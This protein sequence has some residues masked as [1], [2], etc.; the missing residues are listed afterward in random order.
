MLNK[1]DIKQRYVFIDGRTVAGM[2]R[3]LITEALLARQLL[4]AQEDN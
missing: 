3:K 2:T 4:T 1:I